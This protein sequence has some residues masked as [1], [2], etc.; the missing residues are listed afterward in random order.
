MTQ[1]FECERIRIRCLF[2]SCD[3]VTWMWKNPDPMFNILL[4]HSQLNVKE[5]GAY[6]YFTLVTQSL[7]ECERIRI[8]CLFYSCDTVTWMWKN[9]DPM[10]IFLLWHSHLNV[11]ESGSDRC[12]DK[13]DQIRSC[14]TDLKNYK[15]IT[16]FT[17]KL[18]KLSKTFVRNTF[19]LISDYFYIQILQKRAV[20]ATLLYP[21]VQ[22]LY[23]S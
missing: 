13:K 11:K 7:I 3:T 16:I 14:L 6:V 9:P 15:Y 5:S 2:Y 10:F 18:M 22:F 17:Q 20:S 21:I 23:Q 4:W 1:S 19:C 8:R 12:W